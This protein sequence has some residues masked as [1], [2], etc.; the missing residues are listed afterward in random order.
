[1]THITFKNMPF[2]TLSFFTLSRKEDFF[3]TI[4]SQYGRD[5]IDTNDALL[6]RIVK[7]N[8]RIL[9]Q[10][11]DRVPNKCLAVGNVWKCHH[12]SRCNDV[13]FGICMFEIE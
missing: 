1:M 11:L 5:V 9:L 2:H 6:V 10:S 4:I 7:G 3:K 13:W 8:N 12:L